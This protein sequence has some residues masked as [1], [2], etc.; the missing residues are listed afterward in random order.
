MFVFAF[1]VAIILIVSLMLIFNGFMKLTDQNQNNKTFQIGI[2][3]DTED[4]FFQIG[5]K[6]IET[7]DS[8]RFA[9]AFVEVDE[10][11]ASS[12]LEKGE[13]S[14]YV[15]I[16]KGFIEDA[17]SGEINSIKYVTTNGSVG[18][19][20]IFKNEITKV[21]EEILVCSQKGVFGLENA[22]VENGQ[23]DTAFVQMNILNIEYIDL[24][25]NRSETYTVKELGVSGGLSL[26]GYL[27]CGM[28]VLF[29]LIVGLPYVGV[30]VKKDMSLHKVIS[31]K[32]YRAGKQIFSEV[33]SYVLVNILLVLLIA[34]A[35]SVFVQVYPNNYL[36]FW[37]QPKE[38]FVFLLQMLP[39]VVMISIFCIML[40]EF[41]TDIISAVLLHFFVSVS[42]CYISGCLYPIYTFPV[43]VQKIAPFLP[44]GVARVYLQGC[45]LKEF[46]F[47]GLAG[48]VVFSALFYAVICFMRKYRINKRT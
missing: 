2:A 17:M 27:L 14:A 10:N 11:E 13:I 36:N 3:G 33:L 12:Q 43:I 44:T 1:A 18:L 19:I 45:I 35:I 7:F 29:L 8:S 39:V 47:A 31:A 15:V 6:A 16:P 4:S 28:S 25:I 41:A 32:G 21:I 38:I 30:F 48:V 42:L 9:I 26:P 20:A 34:V 46:S 37:L 23:E 24:I 40:F 22:L 5:K